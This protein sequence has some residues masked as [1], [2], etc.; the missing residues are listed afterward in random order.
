MLVAVTMT[1]KE[2]GEGAGSQAGRRQ[3]TAL[4][5]RSLG[6]R[7]RHIS[8]IIGTLQTKLS[9]VQE[10]RGRIITLELSG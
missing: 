2:R 9:Q 1:L 3:V 5:P 8:L 6:L 4:T 10:L 7:V